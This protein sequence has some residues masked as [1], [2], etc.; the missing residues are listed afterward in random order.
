MADK[1][2]KNARHEAFVSK[3]IET[4]GNATEAYSIVYGVTGHTAE[5]NGSRLWLNNAEV[6][7]RYHELSGKKAKTTLQTLT[8]QFDTVFDGAMG[9]AQFSAAG[10]AAA[11]K[12]KLLGFMRDKIEI[13]GP[14]AFNDCKTPSDVVDYVILDAGGLGEAIDM[15]GEL[16]RLLIE[17]AADQALP[18][19]KVED[20]LRTRRPG[21]RLDRAI[22]T[23]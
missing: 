2:L 4:K 1:P 15:V 22:S 17:R 11:A 7:R 3:L 23:I 18:V 8:E 14:G 5:V 16:H 20:N 19:I 10:S 12:A 13:G 6:K 21:P 9:S